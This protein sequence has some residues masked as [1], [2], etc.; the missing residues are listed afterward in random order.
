M[1]PRNALLLFLVSAIAMID[2]V[3]LG[4]FLLVRRARELARKSL[5]ASLPPPPA[6]TPPL[7]TPHQLTRPPS[8]PRFPSSG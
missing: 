8:P 3:L 1:C 4:I 7:L 5:L 6:F 2:F